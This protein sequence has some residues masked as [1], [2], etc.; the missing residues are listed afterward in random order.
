MEHKHSSNCIAQPSLT[1]MLCFFVLMLKTAEASVRPQLP[2][3]VIVKNAF[4]LLHFIP[5]VDKIQK[6]KLPTLKAMVKLYYFV[7]S[8]D[9]NDQK[10]NLGK[11]QDCINKF[12]TQLIPVMW[13]RYTWYSFCRKW[14]KVCCI[15]FH[16][17]RL[18]NP[19]LLKQYTS[20]TFS[21]IIFL[22][23]LAITCLVIS[24][25]FK[26]IISLISGQ[27]HT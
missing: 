11:N 20:A 25:H 1:L 17:R 27:R 4:I 24:H 23:K 14:S 9:S 22:F 7:D 5:S 8:Y 2:S 21:F 16:R 26:S 12:A 18:N 19:V 15:Q 3:N 6:Q 13:W 10:R